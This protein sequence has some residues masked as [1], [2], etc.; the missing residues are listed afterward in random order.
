MET[1][2][3]FFEE[4]FRGKEINFRCFK[5]KGNKLIDFHGKYDLKMRDSLRNENE[6]NNEI[7]FVVN[8][9]GYSNKDITAINAVFVDLDCGKDMNK[10]YYPLQV[11]QEYKENKL[12]EIRAFPIV[13]TCIIETRNGLHCYWFVNDNATADRFEICENLLI[14]HFKADKAVKK[15]CNLMRVPDTYWCKDSNNKFK[16][17]ILEKSDV[18][19]DIDEIVRACSTTH[20]NVMPSV[21]E[22]F[23]DNDKKKDSTDSFITVPKPNA[24]SQPDI[25]PTTPN[26]S[27]V[28]YRQKAT[29]KERLNATPITLHN[30]DDFYDYIKKQDLATFLGVGEGK[31]SCLFH[32]DKNPSANIIVSDSGHHIYYCHSSNCML[33]KGKTIIQI[34]ELLT[35]YNRFKALGFLRSIYNVA[36]YES[37]WQKEQKGILEENQRLILSK[38]FEEGYEEVYKRIKD[39]LLELYTFN[40]L[41][42]DFLNTEAFTTPNGNPVFFA[43]NQ[44][45]ATLYNKDVQR[46]SKHFGLFAYLGLIDKIK[47]TDIP[48]FLLQRSKNEAA[49]KKQKQTIQFYSIPSYGELSLMYSKQKAKEYVEK[50]FT[51]KGFGRDL[52]LRTLGEKEANRVYPKMEGKRISEKNE[53][54]GL[55]VERVALKLIKER[56]WVTEKE[57][58]ELARLN[59]TQI[60]ERHLKA[61]LPELLDKYG[62]IKTRLNKQLKS[63]ISFVGDENSYPIIIHVE[64][65]LHSVGMPESVPQV[66]QIRQVISPRLTMKRKERKLKDVL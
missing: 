54:I 51:M 26:W 58:L 12:E 3:Q 4:L 56:G 14:A 18:R 8:S 47:D 10:E 55:E 9:G 43:S 16:I 13:P 7:Y 46:V 40:G 2:Q 5:H 53:K 66:E 6:R 29:L 59:N 32:K 41:A 49:K 50:G 15:L 1:T 48:E 36:Y 17:S 21:T 11:V 24:I 34:T 63:Q 31:F 65:L 33:D 38:D 22:G 20:Q 61:L 30:H 57:I 60:K 19:Y 44:Y 28:K 27:L 39:Y 52:L 64:E 42:K 35:N 62:L 45:L 25:T 23:G 37:E